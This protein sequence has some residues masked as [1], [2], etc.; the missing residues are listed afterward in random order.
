MNGIQDSHARSRQNGGS[1]EQDTV[2]TLAVKNIN[3]VRCRKA[4]KAKRRLQERG[5]GLSVQQNHLNSGIHLLKKR[6]GIILVDDA[7]IDSMPFSDHTA[8]HI[9]QEALDASHIKGKNLE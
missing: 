5:S 7:E 8:A 2:Q 9:D 6:G 1:R 3:V 4:G